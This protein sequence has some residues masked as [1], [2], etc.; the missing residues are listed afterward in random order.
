M[1]R[2]RL[3]AADYPKSSLKSY[4]CLLLGL[5]LH[6]YHTLQLRFVVES[7]S[8]SLSCQRQLTPVD[9]TIGIPGSGATV[10]GF[11]SFSLPVGCGRLQHG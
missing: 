2:R 3:P 6:A 10:T 11:R 9:P 8:G 5:L 7:I 1:P 4:R